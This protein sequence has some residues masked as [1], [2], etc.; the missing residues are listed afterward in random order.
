MNLTKA[1]THI[2]LGS[3]NA[4]NLPALNAVAAAYKDLCQVYVTH[5]CTIAKS[6]GYADYV[7]PTLLTARWQRVAMQQA[8]GMAQS[9]RTN[10]RKAADEYVRKLAW[11]DA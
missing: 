4:V 8:I 10:R 7:Y 11:Y 5:F 2:R 6:D 3:L 9:W 1:V